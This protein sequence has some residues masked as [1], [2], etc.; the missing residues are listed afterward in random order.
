MSVY[1]INNPSFYGYRVRRVIDGTPHQQY[2]SLTKDGKRVG[3]EDKKAIEKQAKLHDEKLA[4]LQEK[5]RKERDKACQPSQRAEC[6]SGVRGIS[7]R[8]KTTRRGNKEYS[9][10]VFQVNCMSK[11]DS[12]P[13]CT[14]FAVDAHG[15][16]EAWKN[17]VKYYAKHKQI[18]PYTHLLDR[19]PSQRGVMK[20]VKALAA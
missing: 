7:P 15:W 18:Q 6:S 1:L 20:K 12:K 10:M 11:L 14:T 19:V 8:M 4:K 16:E 13:V 3:G 17:A 2:Y 9:Y 5:V